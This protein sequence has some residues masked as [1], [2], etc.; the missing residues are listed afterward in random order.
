MDKILILIINLHTL[1][2]FVYRI[3]RKTF[4]KYIYINTEILFIFLLFILQFST[5]VRNDKNFE[6]YY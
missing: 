1:Y 4:K 5:I 3:L 2:T 6:L